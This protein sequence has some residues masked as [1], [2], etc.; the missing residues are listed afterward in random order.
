VLIRHGPTGLW[1]YNPDLEESGPNAAAY[2]SLYSSSVG[3]TTSSSP[4]ALNANARLIYRVEQRST[5]NPSGGLKMIDLGN[6]TAK[7]VRLTTEGDLDIETMG[8]VGLI[9]ASGRLVGLGPSSAATTGAGTSGDP[10]RKRYAVYT[11]DVKD[12]GGV[13]QPPV[14]WVRDP[15]DANEPNGFLSGTAN[16]RGIWKKWS[17]PYPNGKYYVTTQG[18]QSVYEYTP[19]FSGTSVTLQQVT[20]L[21]L[22]PI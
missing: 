6:L 14:Q 11:A 10:F 5:T 20:G 8:S 2:T 13:G 16:Y 15:V 7:E 12:R 9:Y 17:G 3:Q 4:L 19:T 21:I 22:R 18:N 1:A